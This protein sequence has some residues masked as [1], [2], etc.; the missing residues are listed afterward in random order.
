[1][2]IRSWPV[3]NVPVVA[4]QCWPFLS[5]ILEPIVKS[6]PE[7]IIQRA[8]NQPDKVAYRIFQG[9]V[10]APDVRTSSGKGR[11][12]QRRMDYLAGEIGRLHPITP[13]AD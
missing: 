13:S 4:G 12:A 3:A 7:M 8:R 11:R 9:N 6:L 2:I 5:S 1:M 10:H